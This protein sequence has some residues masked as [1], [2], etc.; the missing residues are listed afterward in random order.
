MFETWEPVDD[1][2]M[3][4]EPELTEAEWQAMVEELIAADP[5]PWP[6]PTPA[7]LRARA[8][9]VIARGESEPMT[10]VL[11]AQL[12]ALDRSELDEDLLV[13]FTKAWQRAANFCE[14]RRGLAVTALVAVCPDDPRVPRELHAAGQLGP[15]LGLGSGGTDTLIAASGQ[16]A[17]ALPAAQAMALAGD[18]SW[19]KATS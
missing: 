16:L 5:D 4:A 19:R 18:L 11:V 1:G 14:A 2:P 8:A 9:A 6:E 17:E 15:A 12:E 3:L 7:Q 10:G 13:G